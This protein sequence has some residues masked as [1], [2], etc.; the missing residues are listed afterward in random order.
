ML[1]TLLTV[2]RVHHVCCSYLV[3]AR[4]NENEECKPRSDKTAK[5]KERC[6]FDDAIDLAFRN[7]E[8][9]GGTTKAE[10]LKAARTTQPLFDYLW[11]SSK[12]LLD[13]RPCLWVLSAARCPPLAARSSDPLCASWPF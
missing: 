11:P 8:N 13:A 3:A 6:L 12:V 10:V 2:A 7:T 9:I 1:C 5:T 4:P